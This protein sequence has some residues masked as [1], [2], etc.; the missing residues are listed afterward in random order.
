[1][2]MQKFETTVIIVGAGPSGLA[3]SACLNLENIPNIVLEKE[4]CSASLWKKRAYDRLKLHL[5]KQFCELPHFPFPPNAT[6]YVPKHVFIQYLDD[7]ASHFNVSPLYHRNVVAATFD[8]G[9]KWRVVAENTLF[10]A[11][12]EYLAKFLVV[13]TGENNEGFIPK[14]LGMETFSGEI[15]HSSSYENG[16]KYE[17]KNVLVVGSGNSGMEIA[18]DLSNWDSHASIVI[19]SPVHFLTLGMVK[20]GMVLLKYLPEAPVDNYGIERPSQG[21]FFLKR[22]IGR[23]P[24]IDVGTIAKIQA[25]EI[26]VLPSIKKVEGEY[27]HFKN[28]DAKPYDAIIFATGYKSVVKKWLKDDGELFNDD[29]MPKKRCPNHWK[30][31]NGLY[32][33]GFA[34]AGLFGIS[35]DAKAI[36]HDIKAILSN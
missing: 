8:G 22:T 30:G 27:I 14:V 17:K 13:A 21:P 20:F 29:G 12:E 7:Y 35:R 15:L 28:G 25:R 24:V 16:K 23:A 4:D 33:V 1:M 9:D 11:T 3:T 5:A 31:E 19:R 26:E 34:R 18:Y 10:G 2:K 32:C 36:A 6:T